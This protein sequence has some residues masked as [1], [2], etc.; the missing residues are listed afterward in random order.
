MPD[1][2]CWFCGRRPADPDVPVVVGVRKIA[3]VHEGLSS[4]K[5]S[6]IEFPDVSIPRCRPCRRWQKFCRSLESLFG[7]SLIFIWPTL[8]ACVALIRFGWA[9]FI[10]IGLA[11]TLGGF[12]LIGKLYYRRMTHSYEDYEKHPAVVGYPDGKAGFSLKKW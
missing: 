5:V 6:Y 8:I 2:T 3:D 9:I 7:F 10:P 12:A 4:T 1:E 11:I